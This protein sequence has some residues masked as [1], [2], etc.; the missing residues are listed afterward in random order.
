MADVQANFALTWER[1]FNP[2]QGQPYA[3]AEVPSPFFCGLPPADG[4]KCWVE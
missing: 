3:I 1:T 2:M 4:L